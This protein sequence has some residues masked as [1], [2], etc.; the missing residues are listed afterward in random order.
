MKCEET[1]GTFLASAT[2]KWQCWHHK[3]VGSSTTSLWGG[4]MVQEWGNGATPPYKNN[5]GR[6]KLKKNLVAKNSKNL[7]N[8]CLGDRNSDT[9]LAETVSQFRLTFYALQPWHSFTKALKLCE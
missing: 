3:A 7:C 9:Q 2:K 6:K 8:A 5:K 1:N 4:E